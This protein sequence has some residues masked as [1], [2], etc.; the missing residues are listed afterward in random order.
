MKEYDYKTN[1]FSFE[2][3]KSEYLEENEKNI[4]CKY[5]VIDES[6]WQ[7]DDFPY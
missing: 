6:S 2:F 3:P 4:C 1:T 7:T 5:H